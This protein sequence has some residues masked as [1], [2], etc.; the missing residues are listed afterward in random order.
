MDQEHHLT[1]EVS[2]LIIGAGPTG[3]TLACDLARRNV[4]FRLVDKAPAYFPGSRG[5]GL[6]P[7]S[8]EVLDDL[9]VVDRIL[10]H[11]RF[12]LPFRAWNGAAIVGEQDLYQD[13]R[14]TPAVPYESPL[15]IPQWRVEETLRTLLQSSGG[16]VEL[17]T[18]LVSI[19]QDEETVTATLETSGAQQQ[20]RCRYLVAADGGRSFVRKFMQF[21][22][23]GE[24]W[25]NARLFVGD[26]RIAGQDAGLDRDH[27]HTWPNHPDGWLG[28]CPLPS[29]ESFQFQAA[30]PPTAEEEEPSLETFQRIFEKRTGRTDLELS[31][32]TWLSLYRVNV[33]MVSRYRNGRVFLAGD[34]AHVHPP[35]GGQ[36][37]NTGIQDAYNL[38]WKLGLVLSGADPSLLD[39]YEEERLPVAASVLGISTRLSREFVAMKN[40]L[41]RSPETLQLSISYRHSS[42]S[43][44]RNSA[45]AAVAPGDRAPDSPLLDMQG[46]RTSLFDLFRGPRFTLLGIIRDGAQNAGVLERCS[47]LA[48]R[49]P[50]LLHACAISREPLAGYRSEQLFLDDGGHFSEAY[51]AEFSFILIRPDGYIGWHGEADALESYLSDVA[52]V[53]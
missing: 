3:L 33:R 24:T 10:S 22:F 52:G 32:P 38:G 5:K 21:G 18:E 12:H 27:W 6:Q 26:V 25:E 47:D 11:G 13:Y 16:Q 14:P 2:V 35:T 41:P 42:L 20:V 40:Y 4:D 43:H 23:E 49:Y 34:A 36:G 8:L 46:N 30:I 7:R 17:S 31:Q 15:I 50:H 28:L 51:P 37:M 39:T 44:P 48:A 1:P 9:G 29:T 19:S 53:R 45:A